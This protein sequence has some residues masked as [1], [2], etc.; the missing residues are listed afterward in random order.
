MREFGTFSP[1]YFSQFDK[2]WIL[3]LRNRGASQPA[4]AQSVR[5][6]CSNGMNFVATTSNISVREPM[7]VCALTIQNPE[8][9]SSYYENGSF[10][11]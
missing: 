11:T 5:S 4:L 8:G 7:L 9:M 3:A 6:L 1:M 10:H 2:T